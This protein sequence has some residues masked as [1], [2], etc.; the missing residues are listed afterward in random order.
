MSNLTIEKLP[1]TITRNL[2]RNLCV[3]YD[4]PRKQVIEAI[5]HGA[6]TLEEVSQKTYACQG[7]GCCIG[8]VERLIE[9]IVDLS[10]QSELMVELSCSTVV[11][12]AEIK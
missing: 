7:S 4:V 9:Q 11:N 5:L 8:Q 3:C 12:Q 2:S 1:K 6:E 10:Q